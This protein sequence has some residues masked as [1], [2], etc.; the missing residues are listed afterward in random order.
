ME[1]NSLSRQIIGS[2][3]ILR[4]MSSN[5]TSTKLFLTQF[6]SSSHPQYLKLARIFHSLIHH[7]SKGRLLEYK[8]IKG[9]MKPQKDTVRQILNFR[10]DNK[11]DRIVKFL[12]QN[13]KTAFALVTTAVWLLNQI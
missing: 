6:K 3:S 5:L 2:S 8:R 7:M 1:V 11:F 10:G 9:V 12:R 13:P 4:Q